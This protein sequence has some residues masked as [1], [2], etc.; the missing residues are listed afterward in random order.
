MNLSTVFFKELA[1]IPTIDTHQHLR[2]S[3]DNNDRPLDRTW[4]FHSIFEN[5]SYLGYLHSGLNSLSPAPLSFR[6]KIKWLRTTSTFRS[7]VEIPLRDLYACSLDD[8]DDDRISEIERQIAE[9]YQHGPQVWCEE[10]FCRANIELGIKMNVTAGYFQEVLPSLSA[11]DRRIEQNLFRSNW[12]VNDLIAADPWVDHCET[13]EQYGIS[14]DS[15]DGYLELIDLIFERMLGFDIVGIKTFLAYSR[16]LEIDEVSIQEARSLYKARALG[17]KRLQDF[18]WCYVGKKAGEYQ[19]PFTIHTGIVP[20]ERPVA[21]CSPALLHNLIR[22]EDCKDT[23]FVL[24]HTGYPYARELVLL[25]WNTANVF[26]DFCWLPLLGFE[27][28]VQVIG[29]FLEWA[30]LHK[31]TMGTDCHQPETTYGSMVQAREVLSQ[32]LA[33]KCAL[34]IWS[35]DMAMDAARAVLGDNARMLYRLG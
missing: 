33:R 20:G 22:H 32:V 25:A 21:G 13:A 34:G 19:L 31:F 2:L 5:G 27:T 17:N 11:N 24:L 30:P 35:E 29:E 4:D 1:K 18:F 26:V 23:R 14:I 10:V 15:L 8:L 28:A 3:H 9:H 7:M 12:L 6:D 16:T